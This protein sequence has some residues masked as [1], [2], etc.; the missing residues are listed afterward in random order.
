MK[1]WIT[2]Y[3][4]PRMVGYSVAIKSKLRPV[5]WRL[6]FG[7]CKLL[8]WTL[9]RLISDTTYIEKHLTYTRS[10]P[11]RDLRVLRLIDTLKLFVRYAQ[12]LIMARS[13]ADAMERN[14][15]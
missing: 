8:R 6:V 15:A 1:K 10:T 7:L 9:E 11:H 12:P 4:T 2:K 14:D 13:P 3:V 5:Y